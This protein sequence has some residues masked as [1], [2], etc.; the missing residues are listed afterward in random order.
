M[1]KRKIIGTAVLSIAMG[2]S[3]FASGA[4]GQ[5]PS[6]NQ[7]FRV[8]I[9]GPASEKTKA[10]ENYGVRWDFNSQGFTTTVNANQY[11]ALLNNKHLTVQKIDSI[12]LVEG[13]VEPAAKPG[14]STSAKPSDQT[15]WG[16]EAIY[17]DSTISATTGGSGIKVAVLDTGVLKTHKDLASSVEQCKD[18]S[19]TKSSLV[20][21]SC[22]DGNGHGTHVS[23][24]ILANGGSDHLGIYGVAPEAKLWSYKVL[25]DRGSG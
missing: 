21:G 22:A 4:F 10:K 2:L 1:K 7:S 13:K 8:L 19:Q 6:S 3:M 12:Q 15:P 14:T 16:I 5:Q 17:N 11:Q 18:F 24:T 20:E 9:Q 25:N 23:G